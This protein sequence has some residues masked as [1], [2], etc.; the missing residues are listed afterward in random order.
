MWSTEEPFG[1]PNLSEMYIAFSRRYPGFS[2]SYLPTP[3]KKLTFTGEYDHL[4][5]V[6]LALNLARLPDEERNTHK[7]SYIEKLELFEKVFGFSKL[8]IGSSEDKGMLFK[9][10]L[11]T[12]GISCRDSFAKPVSTRNNLDRVNLELDGFNFNEI[13]DCFE[14]IYIDP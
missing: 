5:K 4:T 14:P 8:N 2:K 13:E 9:N 10:I 1:I 11:I 12:D 3:I 6:M 7:P